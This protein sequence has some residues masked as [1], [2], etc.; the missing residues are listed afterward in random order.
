MQKRLDELAVQCVHAKLG[1]R[2]I[3][4]R[5]SQCEEGQP[6]CLCLPLGLDHHCCWTLANNLAKNIWNDYGV[7]PKFGGS[8]PY[9]P[10]VLLLTI[11]LL[12]SNILLPPQSCLDT[13]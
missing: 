5:A 13:I 6:L 1:Q 4:V 7:L 12:K 3:D 10:Q 2:Q 11:K 8:G 9:F